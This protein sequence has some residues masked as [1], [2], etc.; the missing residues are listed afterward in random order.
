MITSP[1]N[2]KI[3]LIR[4]LLTDRKERT[5]RKA[6]VVEGVRL[7]EEAVKANLT[8]QLVVYSADLSARGKELIEKFEVMGCSVEEV[9]MHILHG[10][11]DTETPQGILAVLEQPASVLP[12]RWDFALVLDQIRDPG[13]LGTII[14]SA[15]AAGVQAVIL[16]PASVDVYSPKVVR[17]AMGAH[18]RLPL[19]TMTWPEITSTCR[20]HRPAVALLVAD[21]N[22]GKPC[23]ETDLRQPLALVIGS[24]AE[25]PQPEAFSAATGLIHIPMPGKAESLN[26][27]VAASILL[28]EVVR[29]RNS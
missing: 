12:T 15:I 11:S 26:A 5:Q 4:D 17:S 19:L 16:T 8:P 3:K 24:E 27:A 29:Q 2:P 21:S 6:F 10:L 22:G 9:D 7:T 23:W 28:Y 18:F 25:G 20:K 1:H 13:N 14:R